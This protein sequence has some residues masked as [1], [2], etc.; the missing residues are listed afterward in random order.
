M[1]G[2]HPIVRIPSELPDRRRRRK[3]QT[4]IVIITINGKPEFIACIIGI[5][6]TGQRRIFFGNFQTN[7]IHD[8]IDSYTAFCFR[9][10]MT[11]GRQY[12]FGNVFRT[13]QKTDVQ[14]RIRQLFIKATCKKAIFQ[15]IMFYGRMLLD[16][17]ETTMM[18]GKHQTV[19]GNHHSRTETSKADN[20]I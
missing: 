7:Y 20:S 17:A 9:F 14:L 18:I 19:F 1:P 11:G 15:I 13:K 8:R 5:D 6:N 12:P 4:N 3:D 2:P 10:S 16:T